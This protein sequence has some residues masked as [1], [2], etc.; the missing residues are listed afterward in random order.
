MAPKRWDAPPRVHQHR[1]PALVREREHR[2]QAR[3]VERE[4]LRAWMQL[5]PPRA[6]GERTLGL[7]QRVV[8]RVESGEREQAAAARLGLLDHHVVGG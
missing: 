7:G 5:D 6:A 1:Q 8:M 3:V 2:P 4:L